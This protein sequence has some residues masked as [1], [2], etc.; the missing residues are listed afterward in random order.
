MKKLVSLLILISIFAI[1]FMNTTMA[2]FVEVEW[3][4]KMQHGNITM[5]VSDCNNASHECCLSPF[6][7]SSN[8]I[9]NI[10]IKSN[11]NKKLKWKTPHYSFLAILQEDYKINYINK[12]NSPPREVSS[13]ENR[14]IYSNLVWIIKNN[15]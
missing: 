9:S 14:N 10:H 4:T 13:I 2:S 15:S 11:D 1:S 3:E 5:E 8:N 6:K 12:L 7:D